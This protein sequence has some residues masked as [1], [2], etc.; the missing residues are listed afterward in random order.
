[1]AIDPL[2]SVT[3]FSIKDCGI[4]VLGLGCSGGCRVRSWASSVNA[5]NS[6][7]DLICAHYLTRTTMVPSALWESFR[8]HYRLLEL[9]ANA[10]FDGD[11]GRFS[12]RRRHSSG[13]RRR[14]RSSADGRAF[15]AARCPT[16]RTAESRSDPD[17][18]PIRCLRR[19]A[20]LLELRRPDVDGLTVGGMDP[21]EFQAK[22]CQPASPA[23]FLR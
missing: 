9:E 21:G 2:T 10:R 7:E 3:M 23:G 19:R 12:A 4:S 1:M 15:P 22:M 8:E 13:S 11:L 6:S 18:R 17:L 14:S 20:K 5:R 16:D